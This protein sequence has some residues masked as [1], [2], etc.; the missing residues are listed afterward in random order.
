MLVVTCRG[1]KARKERQARF[2]PGGGRAARPLDVAVINQ[3]EFVLG[4]LVPG[5]LVGG[6]D[7]LSCDGINKLVLEAMAG[8]AVYL[9]ERETL[10][11]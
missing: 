5:C 10:R 6:R 9:P 8:A 3:E 2:A 1:W 4:G 7:L 11:C